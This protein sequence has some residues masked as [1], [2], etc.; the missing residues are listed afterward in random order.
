LCH[1]R[2][3]RPLGFPGLD[4][5]SREAAANLPGKFF[6]GWRSQT[7]NFQGENSNS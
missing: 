2:G 6:R 5:T 4:T 3:I 7:R 1:G